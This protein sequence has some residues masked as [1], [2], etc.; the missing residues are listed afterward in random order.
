MKNSDGAERGSD[1]TRGGR[2]RTRIK[3]DGRKRTGWERKSF[4][5][6]RGTGEEWIKRD[7]RRGGGRGSKVMGEAGIIEGVSDGKGRKRVRGKEE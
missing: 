4:V 5:R 6:D 1:E 7:G 2:N 3:R